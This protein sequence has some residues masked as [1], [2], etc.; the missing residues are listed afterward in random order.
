MN[1][2]PNCLLR[3]FISSLAHF[4]PT[5]AGFVVSICLTVIIG[6]FPIGADAATFVVNDTN[7]V[8]DVSPGNGVCETSTGNGICTLRAAI[9]E[10]NALAG[11]DIITLPAGTY[12]HALIAANENVNAGG[13][14]DITSPLTIN[15][16]GAGLTIIQSN[17][18]QNTATERVFHILA[19]GTAVAIDGVTIQNGKALNVTDGGRGAG[20]KAGEN[21]AGDSAI[22]LTITNSTIQ[23]NF[24]DTRGGGLAINK[25][26][27]TITNCGF[28]GNVAGSNV[29][30]SGAGGA[31]FIDSQDNVTVPG[32]NAVITNTVMTNN[33]AE[34]SIVN[35]F[36]GAVIAR[37]LNATV[38]FN[39]CTVSNNQSIATATTGCATGACNGFAGGLYNQQGRMILLNSSISGNSSSH[40]HPGIRN[41]ASTQAAATLD[42]TNSTISNNSSSFDDAQGGGAANIVG[43]SFDAAINIDHSTISGN[44]LTGN[45]SLGGG[46]LN[47]GNTGGSAVMNITNSTISGNSSH[48]VA[49]IYSDGAFGTCVIDFSTITGN[50]ADAASGDGGGIYQDT[51][52]GGATFVSN[53]ISA[54]NVASVNVDINDL[55]TSLNYNH[56]E[57]P[58][59]FF[60]VAANDVIGSDPLLG[61]LANN[62]GP[63]LTHIPGLPVRD[64][65]PTGT[66]GCG[67]PVS[68]DQRGALRPAGGGCDKGS[69]EFDGPTPTPTLTATASPSPTNTATAT[70]TATATNTVT[71]TN[72][73]TST[74]TATPTPTPGPAVNGLFGV[75]PATGLIVKINPGNGI[76]SASFAAPSGISSTTTSIGLSMAES[77]SVLL[78]KNSNVNSTTLFRIDPTSGATLSTLAASSSTEDG[79]SYESNAGTD[80]IFSGHS[81]SDLHRQFGYGGSVT[82]GWETGAPIGGLG[83]DGHGREFG[84]FT[85]G[86]IHEYSPT[87]DDNAFNSTL[88]SPA[89]DVQGMAFDGTNLYVSTASG[90]LYTLDPNTGAVLN[91]VSVAGGALYGLGASASVS[92]ATPTASPTPT[93]TATATPTASPT[94]GCGLM[95]VSSVT[96]GYQPHNYTAIANNTVSYTFSNSVAATNQYAIFQTHDPW[97]STVIKTAITN[98][99]RS[100]TVFTPAQLTGFNFNNYRVVVLNWDDHN[101]SEFNSTYS[102]AIPALENY[103]NSGGVLWIQGAIQ[104]SSYSLPFGGTAAFHANPTAFIMD[105]SNPLMIGV[106][107]PFTGASA[108]HATL[109]GLPAGAA[110]V[111][112][113]TNASGLPILYQL[114]PNACTTPTPTATASPSPTTTSTAT[115]TPTR[116]DTPTPTPTATVTTTPTASPTITPTPCS[117][118]SWNSVANFP[119]LVTDMGVA[120]DGVSL[121]V[122]G[123]YQNGTTV[124][125]TMYRY[126]PGTNIWTALANAPISFMRMEAAYSPISHS[127]YF[128]GGAQQSGPVLN[129]TYIYNIGTNT[130]TTAAPMPG[131][132]YWNSAVYYAPSNKFYVFGGT[133]NSGSGGPPQ[134]NN[135]WEYDPAT[136]LWNTSRQAAPAG[137]S[138]AAVAL[139]GQFVYVAGGYGIAGGGTLNH[140]RYDIVNNT[141]TTLAPLPFQIFNAVGASIG[142]KFYVMGGGNPARPTGSSVNGKFDAMDE[143]DDANRTAAPE[144]SFRSTLIFDP[145]TNGWSSGPLMIVPHSYAG[146][147]TI[148]NRLMIVAGISTN[149]VEMNTVSGDCSTPTPTPTNTATPTFTPTATVTPT[150]TAT[151]TFTPTPFPE[152]SGVVIYPNA[153]GGPIPV[154]DVLVTGYGSPDVFSST[155][156]DGTYVLTGFGVGSYTVTLSK[157]DIFR[158]G[159]TSFDA[160]RITQHVLGIN[161]FNANQETAADV[162]GNGLI[163]SFDAA[164]I[165]RYVLFLSG[166][167]T[168]GDWIFTP[169]NRVYSPP[170]GV[171]TG[172]DYSAFLMG[173]VSGDWTENG[174][175]PAI[176]PERGIAVELASVT[177]STDKEIVVPVN[178]Q[179][180][181]DKEVIAYEF[182]LRYDPSVILPMVEAVDVSGTVSRGLVVVTNAAEPGLLRVVVYGAY[183]IDGDGL[184]LNLRF[185]AVGASGS[186]SPISFER[187]MFNEGES[188]VSVT[189]GKIELF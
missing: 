111:V 10:A 129:T 123:G 60:V 138:G 27:L 159:V 6:A 19:G 122:A 5:F 119:F 11:A 140:L 148:G 127:I 104:S 141:W 168:T 92:I 155:G 176:G 170:I 180:I 136:N 126:D 118:G 78:Y 59:A 45:V 99:A 17:A 13:D 96:T 47:V 24:A 130:W 53:S 54:N 8:Q 43:G 162:S 14:I 143:E 40:Y 16:A 139:S 101:P 173:D 181:A 52:A 81:G 35:T 189:D 70:T 187:M 66:N 100:F 186:V 74:N 182:D 108:S 71:P 103:V 98:A 94:P 3:R 131:G 95:V 183:P 68:N 167:G 163:N 23:N 77:D 175:R 188:R 93:N 72:T 12:T 48:D 133:D 57:N 46:L 82:T 89:A 25:G 28:T 73:S 146:G 75:Q 171:L 149:V 37:A 105:T 185:T 142:G 21:S 147:G 166:S 67:S 156:G 177:A 41:L 179:G 32:Q 102:A 18:A 44:T 49:G 144:A 110:I 124:I 125:N 26:N 86:L 36:G 87:V 9:T 62:G 20:I 117:L 4:L 128:F 51:T 150:N 107:N 31:I 121:F 15:G 165:I 39:G 112:R 134:Y 69:V 85:D 153:I 145:V 1:L 97:G 64:L 115:L 154:S 76:I 174:L 7:D 113:E 157:E 80:L 152:I 58:D 90:M 22:N 30:N 65:I 79:L 172:E 158:N 2:D 161:R 83:G 63:T 184:L 34:S 84:Y 29:G 56:I 151:A 55:P 61:P 42:I 178:V 38:T 106:P 114:G 164:L 120:S 160:A 169:T 137:F 88:P 135:V 91:S 116:T 33:K 132:R 50:V 109:T